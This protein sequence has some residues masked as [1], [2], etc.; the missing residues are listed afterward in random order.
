MERERWERVSE[1]FT[2]ALERPPLERAALL[3]A[4]CAGDPGLRAG[5]EALLA[6]H[7]RAGDF[8]ESGP[9]ALSFTLAAAAEQPELTPGTR[10]GSYEVRERL[11]AG[12]MGVVYAAYHP[13]L[14]R[15]VALKLLRADAALASGREE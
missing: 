14:D 10:V 12:G 11:G 9:G 13:E 15:R 7:G 2:D 4:A 8:L 5:V 3:D 1:I 6:A